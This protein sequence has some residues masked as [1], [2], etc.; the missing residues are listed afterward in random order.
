MKPSDDIEATL[1]LTSLV[2]AGRIT[3][4]QSVNLRSRIDAM[5]GIAGDFIAVVESAA[6]SPKY[7][8]GGIAD[9]AEMNRATA[10]NA[11]DAIEKDTVAVLDQRIADDVKLLSSAIPG[12]SDYEIES[13]TRGVLMRM[14]PLERRLAYLK[15]ARD[16]WDPVLERAVENAPQL[17]EIVSLGVIAQGRD[18]RI[19][20]TNP[21][22][23]AKLEN[24]REH[25]RV[26]AS[27]L[28]RSRSRINAYRS[29]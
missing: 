10:L 1:E 5:S 13:E 8:P 16:G 27:Y 20:R 15:A 3:T 22:Q 17:L 4:E 9:F 11:L 14:D 29:V 23:F 19:K 28:S 25:R 18:E 24:V 6:K 21:A 12:T 2:K 7:T 26:T